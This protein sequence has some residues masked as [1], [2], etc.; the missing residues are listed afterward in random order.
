MDNG[1]MRT[2]AKDNATS[3]TVQETIPP[4]TSNMKKKVIL[5]GFA[6]L[7]PGVRTIENV[8]TCPVLAIHTWDDVCPQPINHTETD[9]GRAVLSGK[10]MVKDEVGNRVTSSIKPNIHS[11][12]QMGNIQ[13]IPVEDIIS[14]S[15]STN[16]SKEIEQ[17]A[18]RHLTTLP[19]A[20]KRTFCQK[21]RDCFSAI[22]CCCCCCHENV[23]NEP[24][25]LITTNPIEHENRSISVIIEYLH[26]SHI[27]TPSHIGVLP[28]SDQMNFYKN[29]LQFE[30]LEFF[31]LKN[32][33]FNPV[34]YAIK[35]QQG[36]TLCRLVMQLK[37]M[38]GNY[39][40]SS[41]LG[42]IIS[43]KDVHLFGD[44]P[45]EDV[46]PLSTQ[47]SPVTNETHSNFRF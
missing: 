24:K 20:K 18:S 21:I 17:Q 3:D 11:K 19:K 43:E 28:T 12:R 32:T 4:P 29:R 13:V 8:Y 44:D 35:R 38:E 22:F 41:Q 27:N 5:Y 26:Y 46:P 31:L 33:E 39:P 25:Y 7:Y 9:N 2:E 1:S 45:Q 23:H 30:T 6:R 36:E 14:I 40:D 47:A 34:K 10:H 37:A 16:A 42:E 15:I